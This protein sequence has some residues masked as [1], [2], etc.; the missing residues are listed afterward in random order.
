[1]RYGRPLTA[2]GGAGISPIQP[3][4]WAALNRRRAPIADAGQRALVNVWKVDSI[5]RSLFSQ[6]RHTKKAFFFFYWN[7]KEQGEI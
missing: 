7:F 1:M 2:T 5:D 4:L 6:K 3:R